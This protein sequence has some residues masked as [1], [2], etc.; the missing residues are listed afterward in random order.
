MSRFSFALW[1]T[2]FTIF[3]LA[4]TVGL[5]IWQLD[6]LAWKTALLDR[7]DANIAAPPVAPEAL[8]GPIEAFEYR[9]VVLRGSFRHDKELFLAARKLVGE[10]DRQA[11][12]DV[13]LQL[14]T[15][16]ERDNG[17]IVLVN[18]GW[19]PSDRRDPA[20][21]TESQVPGP[22][23]MVAVIRLPQ[24]QGM[25]V[26]DN[27]PARNMWFYMDVPGMRE[28]TGLP[29][30]TAY[31]FA[32]DRGPEPGALP[33]GGQTQVNIP[34]D[35]LQYAVTWFLLAGTLVVVFLIFSHRRAREKGQGGPA[36]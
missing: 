9:R 2:L 30:E 21:R 25:L 22:T 6:R 16:F 11:T 12:T 17:Q 7:I 13:G 23:E 32:A 27:D 10:G 8:G 33:I 15:P 19:I 36:R 31:W 26:P 35:H 28:A 5:G 14:V 29:I 24:R 1:P 20:R 3:T 4:V 18:R 34:N